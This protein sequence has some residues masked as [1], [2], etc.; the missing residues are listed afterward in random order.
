MTNGMIVS[1]ENG[2]RQRILAEATRLFVSRGYNGISMREIAEAVGMSKAGLYYHFKDKEDLFLAILSRDLEEMD[3]ILKV[4]REQHTTTRAQVGCLVETIFVQLPEQ[5]ALI[6][7]ASQ[8]MATLSQA[9]RE[10]FNVVYQEKFIGQIE[11]ILS[12]GIQRG[13]LR[14]LDVRLA[15]WSLLGMLYPFFLQGEGREPGKIKDVIETTLT[16]FFSGAAQD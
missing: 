8:E 4:C 1:E 14:A 5:R 3:R 7:M 12:E 2:L 10:A 15:T 13:E 9:A 11:A 16:I 6:R